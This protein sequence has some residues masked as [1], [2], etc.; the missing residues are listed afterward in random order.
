MICRTQSAVENRAPPPESSAR[1]QVVLVTGMSGAGK[2]TALKALEDMDYE[3]V[4]NIPL[5]LL[6]SLVAPGLPAPHGLR[7]RHPH[8]GFRN[9]AVPR[10]H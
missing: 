2:T 4:D 10:R 1:A 8:P 3:A 5:S 9:Q 7:R 6:N